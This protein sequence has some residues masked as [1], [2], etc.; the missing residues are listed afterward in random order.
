MPKGE[1]YVDRYPYIH[2]PQ[3]LQRENDRKRKR[4]SNSFEKGGEI[5]KEEN[6]SQG[7]EIIFKGE[8]SSKGKDIF[9]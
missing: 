9:L 7:G 4:C 3:I 6:F 1:K 5:F 2:L 8:K